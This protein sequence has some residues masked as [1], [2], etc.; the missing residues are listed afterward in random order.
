MVTGKKRS[1]QHSQEKGYLEI[2]D[3]AAHLLRR[4]PI[5]VLSYYYIGSV[6]FVLGFLYFWSDMSRS[7]FAFQHAAEAALSLSLLFI[8]MKCWQSIFCIRLSAFMNRRQVQ[9]RSIK[10]IIQ[11]VVSQTALQASGFIILPLA[12]LTA[13]PF[14]WVYAFYQNASLYGDYKAGTLREAYKRS[15][16]QAM[17]APG[18]NHFILLILSVFGLFVFLNIWIFMY[19]VPHLVKMIS[20]TETMFTKTGWIMLLNTTYLAVSCGVTYLLVDPLMKAIYTL[21]CFYGESLRTGEDLKV[22]LSRFSHPL[23]AVIALAVFLFVMGSSFHSYST[24]LPDATVSVNHDRYQYRSISPEEMDQSISEIITKREFSWRMPRDDIAKEE[25]SGLITAFIKGITDTLKSWL[26]PIKEWIKNALEWIVDK[27][28][29]GSRNNDPIDSS[30]MNPARVLMYSLIALVSG[31]LIFQLW[32]IWKRHE[33][34]NADR[35][36]EASPQKPDIENEE[37]SADELPADSWLD[38]AR[39]L[40]AQGNMRLA[41]RALYLASLSHLAGHNLITIS[42]SKSN[43]EYKLELFRNAHAMPELLSSF[44]DNIM[45]FDQ[46]WYGMYEVTGD[47]LSAFQKNQEQIMVRYEK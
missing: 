8:W 45:L 47:V 27:L 42:K 17:V 46:S 36:E 1:K 40:I 33:R 13:L 26:V 18:Q 31:L 2:I 11:L 43:L 30:L 38:L 20:G 12:F 34:Q 3:E 25:E 7:A 44:S 24:D 32:R 39:D 28:T 41:L 10:D 37:I 19:Q 16:Q 29:P 5:S 6:P 22:E 4:T 14:A 9:Q 23:K 35:V 15:L 21:R